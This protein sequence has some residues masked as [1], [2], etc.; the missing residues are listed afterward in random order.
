MSRS[1]E[2]H[3]RVPYAHIDQM[4][5]VYYANYFVYMEMARAEMLREVGLP[6][7]EMENKGIMLPVVEAHGEYSKP[8]NFDDLIRQAELEAE[9]LDFQDYEDLN[10][11]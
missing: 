5:F 1:F 9:Q 2:H 7:A 11:K 3:V 8:G 4:G 10:L 6:Y